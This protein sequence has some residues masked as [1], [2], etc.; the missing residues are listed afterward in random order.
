ML[1]VA[2]RINEIEIDK[3][4]ILGSLCALVISIT[5][6]KLLWLFFDSL[7]LLYTAHS[8]Q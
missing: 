3:R 8:T 4:S 6:N 2:E 1:K 5:L 7:R